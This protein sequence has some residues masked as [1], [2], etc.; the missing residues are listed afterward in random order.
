LAF[1]KHAGLGVGTPQ[2]GSSS[3][4]VCWLILA[5]MA[6]NTDFWRN[7]AFRQ[8]SPSRPAR[9]ILLAQ[10]GKRFTGGFGH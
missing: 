10:I 4:L 7:D 2:V 9:K 5:L 1:V 6:G 8:T 3:R